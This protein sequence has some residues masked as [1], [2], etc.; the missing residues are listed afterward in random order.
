LNEGTV[1]NILYAAKVF[2][3]EDL[4]SFCAE[5]IER[6]LTEKNVGTFTGQALEFDSKAILNVCLQYFSENT[7]TV[8]SAQEFLSIS[9][10]VLAKFCSAE[11]MACSVLELFN[12]CTSWA[13]N[14]CHGQKKQETPENLQ[15]ILGDVLEEIRFTEMTMKEFIEVV[16]PTKILRNEVVGL[17]IVKLQENLNARGAEKVVGAEPQKP[18]AMAHRLEAD[19]MQGNLNARGAEK[20]VGAEPQKPSATAH[21][22]EAANLPRNLNARGAEKVMG[23]EPRKPSVTAYHMEA[24]NFLR[25][26]NAMKNKK[27]IN[28]RRRQPKA[29]A[30]DDLLTVSYQSLLLCVLTFVFALILRQKLLL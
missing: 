8:I 25:N 9:A 19:N 27:N 13:H 17:V 7:K 28:A 23:A 5:F 15:S 22:L 24:A 29:S 10:E 12:A 6:K 18:S 3:I 26:L 20:V 14:K 2:Q 11:K 16:V 4:E 21:H 1:F 30:E